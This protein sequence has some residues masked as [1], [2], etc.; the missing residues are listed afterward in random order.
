M[1]QMGMSKTVVSLDGGPRRPGRRGRK[2][3]AALAAF[4]AACG[5]GGPARPAGA[6]MVL[7]S[8]GKWFPPADPPLGPDDEPTP[9]ML[10]GTKDSKLDAT[11][12]T[13]KMTGAKQGTWP[14]GKVQK[15]RASDE[16]N[17]KFAQALRD[18]TSGFWK[19]AAEGFAAAAEDLTGF[20]KQEA[21]YNRIEA[22]A[23][24]GLLKEMDGAI[25]DLL[26]AFPKSFFFC[27]AQIKRAKGALSHGDADGATKA[28]EAVKAAPGMNARDAF[29]AEYM[30]VYLTLEV[31][32]KADDA[33]SAYRKLVEAIDRSP[34]AAQGAVTKQKAMAGIGNSLLAKGKAKEATD[35]FASLTDARNADVLAVVYAGL[36]DIAFTEARSL[37]E[38]KK[39][40]EATVRALNARYG[41]D[42]PLAV[43]YVRHWKYLVY[44]ILSRKFTVQKIR[45]TTLRRSLQH[46]SVCKI[47]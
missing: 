45:L 35:T 23:N 34:D 41:L 16:A 36:G 5:L 10:E 21:L 40:P 19:D 9:E 38:Q 30:R 31:A 2:A 7:T 13:V 6:D 29:R 3:L 37:R 42:Q 17:E 14:A 27:D 18:V 39:L 43:Q 11:Y 28:L 26:Q 44:T 22:Y 15:L 20:G 4:M 46:S 24:A 8:D 33:F 47:Q 12:E 1:S 32:G 25:D